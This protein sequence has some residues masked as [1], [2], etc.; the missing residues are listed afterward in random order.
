VGPPGMV[1]TTYHHMFPD[2]RNKNKYGLWVGI[3]RVFKVFE[4]LQFKR[5]GAIRYDHDQLTIKCS[6]THEK[7]IHMVY[8]WG[9]QRFSIY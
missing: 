3:S 7:R 5:D 4:H 2:T 9:S 8:G 1:M 6:L